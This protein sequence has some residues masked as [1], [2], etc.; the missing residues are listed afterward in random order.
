MVIMMVMWDGWMNMIH[1]QI[2]GVN[3]QMLPMQEIIL[4]WALL[5]T[6]SM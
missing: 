4:V 2:L 5:M 6:S 1:R 3:L